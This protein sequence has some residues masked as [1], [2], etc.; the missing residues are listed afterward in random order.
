MLSGT[1]RKTVV[2]LDFDG[3]IS[4]SAPESF[5]VALATYAEFRPAAKLSPLAEASPERPE[6]QRL[7]RSFLSLMPLGNRA[8]DYFVALDAIERGEA[9]EDQA[10]YDVTYASYEPDLLMDFHRRLYE[11]R[12]AWRERDPEGWCRLMAP[13]PGMRD[14]LEALA[15]RAT[16]AIATAKDLASVLLLL[17]SYGMSHLFP[18]QLLCDKSHGR[19]KAS[20]LRALADTTGQRFPDITF[21]DDKLNHLEAVAPLGVRCVL[22]S[23]GYNS[24]REIE[25]ARE[26]GFAVASL[27]DAREVLPGVAR[28]A[29]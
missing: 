11:R 10:A 19:E 13:Y 21:V 24:E 3:V 8:E 15:E 16:L 7:Y 14:I 28:S 26:R 27:A 22:A 4:D 2:A 9:I 18:A 23:W 12:D 1:A 25:A 20:H 17:E 5:A 6:R 29:T